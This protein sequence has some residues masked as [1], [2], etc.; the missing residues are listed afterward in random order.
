MI[1]EFRE[2]ELPTGKY[3]TIERYLEQAIAIAQNKAKRF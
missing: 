3:G 1:H 2:K